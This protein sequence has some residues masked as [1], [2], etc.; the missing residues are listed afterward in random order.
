MWGN[1]NA[2][3]EMIYVDDLADACVYFM[4]KKFRGTI[5]NIGTGRDFRIKDYVKIIGSV[6]V[7]DKN[8]KIQFDKN[9]PNGT[10][11]KLLNISRSKKYGWSPK[12]DLKDA[13][14]ETYKDFLKKNQVYKE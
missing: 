7:P 2:R 8:I 9:K 4:N 11:R 12:T 6:I 14:Y 5:I 10:P 3:R 1:G 13:I